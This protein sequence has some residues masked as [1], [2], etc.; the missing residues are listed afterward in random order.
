[1]T[2]TWEKPSY[3]W[4]QLGWMFGVDTNIA[5]EDINDGCPELEKAMGELLGRVWNTEEYTNNEKQVSKQDK[6]R[7]LIMRRFLRR[8]AKWDNTYK[9]PFILGVSKV[10]DDGTFLQ[11]FIHNYLFFWD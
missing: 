2:R 7:V 9:G 5:R 1:M 4:A 11:I 10:E 3:D 8:L 6:K